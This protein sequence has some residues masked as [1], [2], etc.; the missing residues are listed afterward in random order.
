ME[1]VKN[2][3]FTQKY[4]KVYC[5][6]KDEQKFNAPHHFEV[7]AID[8]VSLSADKLIA[9][10]DFQEG[11][12]KEAGINGVANEDLLLMVLTRLKSFQDTEWH[13]KENELAITKIEE[14]VM[15]LRKRTLER[16]AR[17]VEGTSII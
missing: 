2:A 14:A 17:N 9:K 6:S 11:P 10:I 4:T 12:I 1:E 13:S 8:P 7:F 3:L 16:E 5:E 15:W